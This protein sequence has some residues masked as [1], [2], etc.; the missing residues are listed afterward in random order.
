MRQVNKQNPSTRENKWLYILVSIFHLQFAMQI[1]NNKNRSISRSRLHSCYGSVSSVKIL[2]K[3]NESK[4]FWKRPM[5]IVYH[6]K[7]KI[8][9]D[10]DFFYLS[11]TRTKIIMSNKNHVSCIDGK[12]STRITYFYYY[13]FSH[14][15]PT[16]KLCFLTQARRQK[17]LQHSTRPVENV[18]LTSKEKEK[19][20]KKKQ[21]EGRRWK[22]R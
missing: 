10:Q 17:K 9:W 6:S 7:K 1:R 3:T 11:L 19:R 14:R 16:H 5:P 20:N 12:I 2:H 18:A 13:L 8:Q 21:W 15:S 22:N 4:S